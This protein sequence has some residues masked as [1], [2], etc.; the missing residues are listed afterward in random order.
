MAVGGER[1]VAFEHER[2][3]LLRVMVQRE[4]GAGIEAVLLH[5]RLRG[6]Q[7]A[8]SDPVIRALRGDL[9][10]AADLRHWPS[11][12]S[13]IPKLMPLV[14]MIWMAASVKRQSPPSHRA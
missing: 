13:S 8:T 5:R 9:V 14:E 4:G 10:E 1:D 2:D 6:R 12:C 3:L 7:D 11:G